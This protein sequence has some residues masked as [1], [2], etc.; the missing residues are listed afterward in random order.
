MRA[1]RYNSIN[2]V[3]NVTQSRGIYEM[4]FLMKQ[5][6]Q[7]TRSGLVT[8]KEFRKL[9]ITLHNQN[10]NSFFSSYKFPFSNYGMHVFNIQSMYR[11]FRFVQLNIFYID[12]KCSKIEVKKM[13]M[14]MCLAI[15]NN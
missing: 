12:G 3:Q 6:K 7:N 4:N 15:Q 11:I 1:C 10:W 14:S 2:S 5:I 13:L 9:N 8:K